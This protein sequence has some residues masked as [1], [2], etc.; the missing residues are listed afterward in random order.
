MDEE[1][2]EDQQEPQTGA[3]PDELQSLRDELAQLR[4]ELTAA[5]DELSKTRQLNYTLARQIDV[6][7]EAEQPIE[8]QLDALFG[9]RQERR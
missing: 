1:R 6:S 2:R 3:D 5:R 8:A 4:G 9:K 7:R